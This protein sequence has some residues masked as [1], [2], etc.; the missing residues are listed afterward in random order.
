MAELGFECVEVVGDRY[1]AAPT[2]LFRVRITS[3]QRVPAI[4]LRCQIRAEPAKRRYTDGEAELLVDVFGQQDR[5]G[6]SRKPMQFAY[7]S[8]MV[9]SFDDHIEVSLPVP[10]TYDLEVANGK[11]LHALEG[12]SLAMTL[13][14][15]GTVFGA[16]DRGFWV[17]QVPWHAE[18]ACRL[19]PSVWSSL[20]DQYFPDEGWLRIRRETIDELMRFKASRGYAT[21]DETM[22]SL[23]AAASRAAAVKSEATR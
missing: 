14:F 3:A 7:T 8:A 17:E 22:R 4:A 6:E 10:V 12:D 2:L 19:A 11:L 5:W 9:P 23:V 15:S 21:W 1:A 16:G 20:M 13:M 18:A